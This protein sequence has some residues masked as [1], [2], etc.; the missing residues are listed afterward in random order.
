[1]FAEVL[2]RALASKLNGQEVTIVDHDSI[3]L[4]KFDTTVVVISDHPRT[5]GE[6]I[7]AFSHG[8]KA[9]LISP[10]INVLVKTIEL[11]SSEDCNVLIGLRVPDSEGEIEAKPIINGKPSPLSPKE[12]L[13]VKYLAEGCSNKVLARKLNIAESTV[14]VHVKSVLRKLRLGNR[15]QAAMWWSEQ[16]IVNGV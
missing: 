6:I 12:L 1:M 10:S 4:S 14:K 5:P 7:Q 9:Y 15:T 11:V 16:K 2:H 3:Q 13:V 8:V